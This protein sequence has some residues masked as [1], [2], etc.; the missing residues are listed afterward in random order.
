MHKDSGT[1]YTKSDRYGFWHPGYAWACSRWAW[2]KMG[3]LVDWAILGSADRHMAMAWIQRVDDS[4][5][6]NINFNYKFLLKVFE[7]RCKNFKMSYTPGTILHHW[8]GSLA[9]RKYKERWE[10]LTH[11]DYDPSKD[12]E[13]DAQGMTQLSKKGERL[14]KDIS[15]YFSER[16]EDEFCDEGSGGNLLFFTKKT[17]GSFNGRVSP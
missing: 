5:P 7:A 3:G 9:N 14:K 12:L 16:K 11:H 4:G 8:H 6:G 10:I 13:T 2:E 15:L 17:Y 1:K